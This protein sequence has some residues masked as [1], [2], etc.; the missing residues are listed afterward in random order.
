MS[1]TGVDPDK[2]LRLGREVIETEGRAVLELSPR[3]GEDFVAA[4]RVLYNCTGRSVVTG[5]GKSGHVARKVAATLAS[6][7]TPA[8]FIHP[9]EAG[10]GD[11]GMITGQD[12]L[13]AFSNSGETEE[14]C[15]L[16]PGLKREPIPVVAVTGAPAS[17]LASHAD[18][19]LDV[20]VSREACPLGLAPTAS[21]TAALAMGDALAL[22]L[23]EC[24]GFGA[25]DFARVHPGG[26]L[27]RR[28]LLRVGDIML[29]GDRIPRVRTGCSLPDAL[30]EMS[31]KG[32]GATLVIDPEGRVIGIYTDGDLRRT[33]DSGA[34]LR[35]LC[36]DRVMT[37]GFKT[38][39]ADALAVV[40]LE[41]MERH[42]INVLPA[43]HPDGALAGIVNMHL[44]LQHK[45]V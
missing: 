9:G 33:L 20:S 31:S 25:E 41:Q 44:L 2:V 26:Q 6:T 45:V 19:H 5:M 29:T 32:L 7:G 23:L 18:V 35:P 12:A 40:A 11:L 22:A 24:R 39:A 3:L 15:A 37:K 14:L 36:I 43:M 30:I 27:G 42:R 34:D 1:R 21:T 10:H 17:T 16:L 4:C 38:V 28:L 13:L 8:F